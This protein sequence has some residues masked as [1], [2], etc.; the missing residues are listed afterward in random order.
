MSL[1][2]LL[3]AAVMAAVGPDGG[4]TPIGSPARGTSMTLEAPPPHPRPESAPTYELRPTK[5]GSGDLLYDGRT[6]SARVSTDGSVTFSDRRASDV[7]FL[8]PWL[9]APVYNGVPSLQST[10]TSLLRRKKAPQPRPAP[11]PDDSFLVIPNVTPYRPDPREACRECNDIHFDPMLVG[12]GGHFDLADELGRF[13]GH[14]PHR[15]EKARFLGATRELR[16][17][18]AVAAH[19]LWIRRATAELPGRLEAI[20]CA[21]DRPPRE[22]RAI[23]EALRAEMNGSPEGRAAAARIAAF[24][25]TRFVSDAAICPARLPAP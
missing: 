15:L 21:R 6:W 24:I 16:I 5:D 12:G 10:V 22:R 18:M 8:P 17:R 19:A 23:L 20:A 3:V 11:P 2:A 25:D 13:A 9:P 1:G 14:D 7:G 4:V